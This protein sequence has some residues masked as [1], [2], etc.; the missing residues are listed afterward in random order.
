MAG[1][2]LCRGGGGG[3]CG[4]PATELRQ[5]LVVGPETP[6]FAVR[7]TR[8]GATGPGVPGVPGER[9]SG[10]AGASPVGEARGDLAVTVRWRR[11]AV[12]C[13]TC[14]AIDIRIAEPAPAPARLRRGAA[15]GVDRGV[16]VGVKS[17]CLKL[18]M[19]ESRLSLDKRAGGLAAGWLVA[20]EVALPGTAAPSLSGGG[21]GGSGGIGG[22]GGVCAA[23]DALFGSAEA[24][25]RDVSRDDGIVPD[26]VCRV[27][28]KRWLP[29]EQRSTASLNEGR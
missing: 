3:G 19:A 23:A 10:P 26:C 5:A 1:D 13:S 18:R 17:L 11:S 29:G 6:S 24:R 21:S 15:T 16:V 8:G 25:S 4:V 7:R 28:P 20:G 22:G 14:S 9:A 2:S 12:T 27:L